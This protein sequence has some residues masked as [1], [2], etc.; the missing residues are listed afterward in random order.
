MFSVRAGHDLFTR[1]IVNEPVELRQRWRHQ[2]PGPRG[3]VR[4]SSTRRD[5]PVPQPDRSRHSNPEAL[6]Q[7]GPGRESQQRDVQYLLAVGT[8]VSRI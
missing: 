3:T 2:R 7:V 1:I 5:T 8:R 6:A 4:F